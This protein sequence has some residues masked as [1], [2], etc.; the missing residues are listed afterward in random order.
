MP[1]IMVSN[2]KTVS[3]LRNLCERPVWPSERASRDALQWQQRGF[4]ITGNWKR[5]GSFWP[6]LKEFG[7]PPQSPQVSCWERHGWGCSV[8]WQ[9]LMLQVLQGCMDHCCTLGLP[10]GFSW[11]KPE[12]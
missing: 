11:P 4:E 6:A 8:L 5:E 7:Q 3:S 1:S 2:L 9:F 10:V 12:L